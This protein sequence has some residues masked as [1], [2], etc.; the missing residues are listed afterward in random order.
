MCGH[1]L[2]FLASKF[3]FIPI[4]TLAIAKMCVYRAQK[5]TSWFFRGKMGVLAIMMDKMAS[6]KSGKNRFISFV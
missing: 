4:N 2:P 6:A 3:N 5:S 1:T